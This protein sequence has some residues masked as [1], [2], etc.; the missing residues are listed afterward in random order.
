MRSQRRTNTALI[1]VALVAAASAVAALF[2]VFTAR[3]TNGDDCIVLGGDIT[4]GA[5]VLET[6]VSWNGPLVIAEDLRIAGSGGILVSGSALDLTVAGDLLLETPAVPGGGS[7]RCANSTA[8]PGN[9]CSLAVTADGSVDL[10]AG[11]AF[12]AEKTANSGSGGGITVRSGGALT[13]AGA[14]GGPPGALIPSSRT[15]TAG[16]GNGGDIAITAA[17][18]VVAETGAAIAAD[19]AGGRAG[20]I[21]LTSQGTVVIN[22]A[23]TAGPSRTVLSQTMLTGEALDGGNTGQQGGAISIT[24]FADRELCLTVGEDG[25][26]VSQGEDPGAAKVTLAA[27]GIEINGLVASISKQAGPSLVSLRSGRGISVNGQ[28]LGSFGPRQGRICADGNQTGADG[29]RV[30]LYAAED[31]SVSGPPLAFMVPIPPVSSDPGSANS[32]PAGGTISVRTTGG[33]INVAGNAM[34]AGRNNAGN[35]GGAIEVAALLDI[36]LTQASIAAVGDFNDTG[37]LGD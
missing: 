23:I 29:Y 13:L 18:P 17:G 15:T 22:G 32:R 16:S 3:A 31:I 5:C 30:E 19:N 4:G 12:R 7:I 2:G 37:G 35:S 10:H 6:I 24:A 11:S 28:D 21:A 33:L 8:N 9:A 14:A 1:V 34:S 26:I 36:V 25:L 27:C 20:A